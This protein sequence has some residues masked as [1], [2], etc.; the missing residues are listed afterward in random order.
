MNSTQ[1][2]TLANLPKLDKLDRLEVNDNKLGSTDPHLELLATLYPNLR[3]LK[4]SN[5]GLKGGAE[6][7]LALSK[8]EHLDTLDLSNNPIV[9][10]MGEDYAMKVRE[11]L[12]KV[13]V[14]DG[15]N[16]EG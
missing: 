1:L 8:C 9:G 10:E 15:F 4:I 7:I 3:V 13:E 6:A 14:L 16:R 12:P 5:N 11:M 2:K